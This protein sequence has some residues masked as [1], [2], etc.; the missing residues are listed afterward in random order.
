MSD[1]MESVRRTSMTM[2]KAATGMSGARPAEAPATSEPMAAASR[3]APTIISANAELKGSITTTDT[4][5][6]RGKI[7]GDVRASA[8][9]VCA[10]GKIK[11]DLTA[12]TITVQGDVEG[13]LQAQD[14]RLQAGANVVGEIAHGSL[15]IDTAAIF[16]GT[17]KRVAAPAPAVAQ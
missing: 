13:R 17:I 3:P 8:I 1:A 12:E 2:L 10:G 14:V 9:T 16:E 15:G 4:I 11:G 7:E 6:I 5:E